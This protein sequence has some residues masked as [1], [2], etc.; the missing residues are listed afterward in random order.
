MENNYPF[1]ENKGSVL[2]GFVGA[3]IGAALGAVVWVLVGMLGY[4]AS[5]V[6]LLIAFLAGKG[7]DL[8]H[9]RQGKVKLF[10]LILYVVL[11]VV[12]GTLGTYG[13]QIHETYHELVNELPAEER[14]Y[15]VSEAEFFQAIIPDLMA[16]DEFVGE[17]VKSIGI[18]LVFAVLG[19][20]GLLKG[21]GKKQTAVQPAPEQAAAPAE[22][23]EIQ[24]IA[25]KEQNN[26]LHS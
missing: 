2:G 24:Q 21:A 25:D 4:I 11:A 12:G 7:Y 1:E 14:A 16:E 26:N 23:P 22:F 8:L 20:F 10:I 18:G 17:V 15:V 6:G 3:L 5:I 13:W 9:G 19:C